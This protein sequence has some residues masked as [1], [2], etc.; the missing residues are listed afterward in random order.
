MTLAARLWQDNRDLA[1]ANLQSPFVQGILGGSLPRTRFAYYVGQDA[2][3][4]ES[5]ARA[6]AVCGARAPDWRSFQEFHQLAG[7]VLSELE[8]HAGYAAN[9]QVD[10]GATVAGVT[11]RRYV[12]FLLATAWGGSVGLTCAAMA[13]CMRLYAFLGQRL[14]GGGIPDHQYGAWIRTYSDPEFEALARQ[15]EALVDRYAGDTPA[16]HDAY[17]YAMRCELDFFQSAWE[18]DGD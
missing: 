6:Y 18:A 9:W 7:G 10:L 11:T 12:D 4:L 13:P 17:R 16:T 8:L 2:Y 1:E 14:A 5:F 3:F 15:L